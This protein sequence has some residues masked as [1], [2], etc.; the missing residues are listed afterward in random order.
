MSFA[1]LLEP[2][3][4]WMV[5]RNAVYFDM[6]PQEQ[7]ADIRRVSYIAQTVGAELALN[8]GVDLGSIVLD[9]GQLVNTGISMTASTYFTPMDIALDA[10]RDLISGRSV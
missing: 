5:G 2:D 3:F 1:E 7:A 10:A 8:H 6:I 4:L 9:L